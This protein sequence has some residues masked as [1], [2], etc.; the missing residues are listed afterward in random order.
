M[1]KIK[2]NLVGRVITS[3]FIFLVIWWIYIQLLG[4]QTSELNY[5]FSFAYGLIPLFSGIYFLTK[6]YYF[7]LDQSRVIFRSLLFFSLGLIAWGLGESIWSY[8]NLVL[9]VEIPY[10][11]IADFF[12]VTTF[13]MF[14]LGVIYLARGLGA[15]GVLKN[16]YARMLVVVIPVV[17]LVVSYYLLI[18]FARAG[19]L[20]ESFEG[21]KFFFDISYPLWDA[22]V[23]TLVLLLT[24]LTITRLEGK[25]KLSVLLISFGS[26]LMFLADLGFAHQT[27]YNTFYNGGMVDLIYTISLYCLSLGVGF[28]E[29][30]SL[31][32]NMTGNPNELL[33]K[34]EE[35]LHEANVKLK[36]REQELSKIN[37]D[38]YK[39]NLEL[40]EEKKKAEALLYNISEAAIV[41]DNNNKILLFNKAAQ[42]LT[43]ISEE[44][45]KGKFF[46]EVVLVF[47]EKGNQITGDTIKSFLEYRP[48]TKLTNLTLRRIDGRE[49]FV[50]LTASKVSVKA[51]LNLYVILISD[52][53]EEIKSERAREEFIS[54]A[55][56]ELRTP[57]TII[58]NYL[59]MLQ[60]KKGGDL[61]PR[62][63]EFVTKAMDGTERM[64]RLIRDFL[65]ISRMEQGKLELHPTQVDLAKLISDISSDFKIKADQKG[66]E[67]KVR[68]E[69]KL[70][71]VRADEDKL[72][73]VVINLIGNS[74]KFTDSGFVSVIAACE[75]SEVKTSVIDTGKGIAKEDLPRL[76]R[77][78]GRLDNTFV[79]AAESGGTGLGL[80]IVKSI[81]EIM[82]GK[83]GVH[84]EGVGKGATFWFTLRAV[85]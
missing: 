60:N 14:S 47:D 20:T 64:I 40:L 39:K 85:T 1:F 77:K 8:Y 24:S 50:N 11:S 30:D 4:V 66:V 78:F 67:L 56:H 29:F 44:K 25:T 53:T 54:I 73:E 72:R 76:F 61:T 34:T 3:Y 38:V 41:A 36:Q 2:L 55:S 52:V 48:G 26:I 46:K 21:L 42:S 9:N 79:T 58:K 35:E 12:Y 27:T 17:T 18:V 13:P 49:R 15:F 43:T 80:Y 33:E 57:M 74:I 51:D 69:D 6:L 45:A 59:W 10:P 23:L 82:G 63:N 5:L 81:V 84:S 62:Q 16:R 28:L 32:G 7:K 71:K 31:P 83:V 22:I 19:V 68:I 75:G 65:D 70:P 37:E